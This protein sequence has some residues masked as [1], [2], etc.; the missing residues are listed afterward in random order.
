[1]AETSVVPTGLISIQPSNVLSDEEYVWVDLGVDLDG[2]ARVGFY[3]AWAG[4]LKAAAVLMADAAVKRFGEKAA[5]ALVRYLT[6]EGGNDAYNKEVIARL[7]RI[8]EALVKLIAFMTIH[9]VPL[10]KKAVDASIVESNIRTL[11]STA[12]AVGNS[13][14]DYRKDPTQDKADRVWNNSLRLLEQGWAIIIAGQEWHLIASHAISAVIPAYADLLKRDKKKYGTSLGLWAQDYLPVM[15][16]WVDPIQPNNF[17]SFRKEQQGLLDDA[18]RA[19]QTPPSSKFLLQVIGPYGRADEMGGT[20]WSW[21]GI[22]AHAAPPGADGL[23]REG[24]G[25]GTYP[26]IVLTTVDQV[27]PPHSAF[28]LPVLPWWDPN[29]NAHPRD[30]YDRMVGIANMYTHRI[31]TIPPILAECT[32]SIEIINNLIGACKKLELLK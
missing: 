3:V 8:E 32:T 16:K 15:E 1:M 22:P 25:Y 31:R 30:A 6:G 7:T 26:Q 5:E 13:L 10:I 29:Y 20:I 21:I 9:M 14:F 12:K 27:A 28:G 2:G 11:Q 4:L 19:M 23:W 18:K 24:N 17:V